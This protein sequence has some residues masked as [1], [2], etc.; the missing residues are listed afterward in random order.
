MVSYYLRNFDKVR[1]IV[2]YYSYIYYLYVNDTWVKGKEVN[3]LVL[4]FSL[5]V[6]Q[7]AGTD[8]SVFP[9][10]E[11]QDFFLAAQV[12]FEDLFKDVRKLKRELTGTATSL[13][14]VLINSP[15]NL[16]DVS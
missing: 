2:I 12:K 5:F 1:K 11:P 7:D 14:L 3:L 6:H 15:F 16:N 8:K 13:S 9:L 4:C 10:P